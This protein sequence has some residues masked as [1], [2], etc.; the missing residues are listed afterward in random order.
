M[1]KLISILLA[2]IL[3]TGLVA[4][5]DKDNENE[6]NDKNTT[7]SA[8][9]SEK[10]D[11]TEKSDNVTE[12]TDSPSETI[13]KTEFDPP[14][15]L[16]MKLN[17]VYFTLPIDLEELEEKTG[18]KEVDVGL[19][20]KGITDGNSTFP[21][22]I[23]AD[24]NTVIMIKAY[25]P[26]TNELFPYDRSKTEVIFPAGVTVDTTK[27][28]IENGL[29]PYKSVG[30]ASENFTDSSEGWEKFTWTPTQN[31]HCSGLSLSIN[32][33]NY[34]SSQTSRHSIKVHMLRS[35]SLLSS[36]YVMLLV[37]LSLL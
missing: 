6:N 11:K 1:K 18:F 29:F 36:L 17:G 31:H 21:V 9:V 2:T 25:A 26:G 24:E 3:L 13:I 12:K 33:N 34:L 28:E 30:R 5:G 19:A 8:N 16:S 37:H 10:A 27:E 15:V 20:S 22:Y 23:N 32:K 35:L 14:E 7:T 4:C